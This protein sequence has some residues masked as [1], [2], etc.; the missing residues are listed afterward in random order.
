MKKIIRWFQPD[1]VKQRTLEIAVRKETILF[2]LAS[3]TTT[4]EA[5]E[6]YTDISETFL[7]KVRERL[8]DVT[9]EKSII[10]KFLKEL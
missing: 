2:N 8:A 1:K 10:E 7:A 9:E 3:E 4:A 6:I 5:L